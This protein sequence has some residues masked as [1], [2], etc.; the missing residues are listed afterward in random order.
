[1][2]YSPELYFLTLIATATVLMWVPYTVARIFTRGL[3]P[4]L[5]NPD[6]SFKADP[7][8]AERARRAHANAVEN[9]VVFATLVLT[10]AFVGIS[11][12]ATILAAKIYLFT[13]LAHYL[14]YAAG[15]PVLRTLS[16]VIGWAATLVFA[17]ALLSHAT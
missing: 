13:R 17:A 6:P 1:M 7:A 8:W 2:T 5:S 12:P 15:V 11:T 9:L 3:M 16:F 4:A 14:L 10:A